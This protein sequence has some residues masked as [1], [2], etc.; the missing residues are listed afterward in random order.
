MRYNRN[1]IHLLQSVPPGGSYH[2]TVS[3]GHNEWNVGHN[4]SVA[5]SPQAKYTD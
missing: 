4:I 1:G 2:I 5:L 3:R